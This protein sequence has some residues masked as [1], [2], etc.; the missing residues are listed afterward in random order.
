MDL[1]VIAITMG[2]AAGIGP[3]L[4]AKA[5]ADQTVR[6]CCRPLVI[7]DPVVMERAIRVVGADLDLHQVSQ[8]PKAR[9]A[10]G[11]MDVWCPPGL[12][13]GPA[14]WGR[15]DAANGEA[16][17]HCLRASFDL[18]AEGEVHGVISA[19]MNK[20]AFHQAGYDYADEL[21]Y[22]GEY[23]GSRGTF[24]LGVARAVWTIA[25]AEHLAFRQIA[26]H[27]TKA[28][29]LRCI[30]SMDDALRRAGIAE[31]RIAVA[32]LNVHAGEG[33]LYGRE[34]VDEISPA[35][36]AARGV[37]I[38]A[39]GPIPADAVFP[40]AF[41]GRFH[42]V[43]CMYHDQA[44]IARKL[45]PMREG[46][47]IFMGL[48]APCGTTAHGTAFDIAGQGIAD[49]GSLI[50]AIGYTARMAGSLPPITLSTVEG[51]PVGA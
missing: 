43:V 47:T 41:A 14:P 38:D 1:P 3:E 18:V 28:R 44:N 26:D 22:L 8:A 23:T 39:S 4:I 51:S 45:Q 7:A 42:G 34:E 50:A 27:V 10:P 5:L 12:S 40:Q 35:I 19:P 31:P 15:L 13:L 37:G 11:A 29:V 21:V 36:A 9:F 30:Q 49:P 16:A 24:I 17:A 2:D 25:V 20:D 48:P 33:G 32:A 6:A 46:A